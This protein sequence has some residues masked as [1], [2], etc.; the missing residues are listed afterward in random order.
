MK[1]R[2]EIRLS[3]QQIQIEKESHVEEFYQRK[4]QINDKRF[5]QVTIWSKRRGEDLLVMKKRLSFSVE[6]CKIDKQQARERLKLNHD[7]LMKMVDFSVKKLHSQKFEV[8]GFYQ[9]P[10]QDLKKEINRRK[11]IKK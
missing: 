1:L 11:G 7:Y 3:N 10:L 6:D 2:E 8:W 5:G 4:K 9:A